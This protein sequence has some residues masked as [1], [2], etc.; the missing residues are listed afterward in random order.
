MYAHFPGL[1]VVVPSTP[2]D[3]KGLLKTALN[4]D[5]PVLFLEPR[6]L[7]TTKGHVPQ[8]EYFIEFGHAAIVREGT[9]ATIVGLGS[10]LR[11][12]I[13]ARETLEKEGLSIEIIDP[14]TV[15]PLDIETILRS[16]V[17]TGR[18]LIVDESF[19]PCGVG[20]EIAAQLAERGFDELDAP[21]RRINGA[22]TPTPYSP[23]L[24]AAVVPSAEI[25]AKAIRDLCDE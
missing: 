16:V 14:R 23:P 19:A 25:I 3:A 22:H 18:L 12:I 1:R 17:K 4:C 11:K 20:A 8:E 24:E 21:I 6:E 10:M 2:Y 7:L 15:A 9:D 5:D 13:D